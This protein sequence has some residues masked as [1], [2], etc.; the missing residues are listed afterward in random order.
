M[1]KFNYD[2]YCGIYC[3]ACDIMMSYK[4]GNKHRL[5][6]FWNESTVKTFQN[7]LGLVY[8]S[9]KPFSYKC[10]GCKTDTLF[11]NCAVCQIRKCAIN[12]KVE[13][14]IDCE[15]YPCKPIVDSRKMFSLLPHI[16]SN[17]N[18]MEII[19]KVGVTQWLSEQEKKWKC[20]NC[21]TNFSWYTYK[22]KNCNNDLKQYSFRFSFL[23]SLILRLA[24]IVFMPIQK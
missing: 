6:S 21:N 22:C 9:G 11:V 12:S 7:K 13:H 5:A 15:K 17:R 16:K 20:P 1:D 2:S 14:C 19:K 4:T 18:N 23:Q 8:D 24:I 3:G 10:N